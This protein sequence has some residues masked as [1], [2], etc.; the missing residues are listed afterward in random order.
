MSAK[1]IDDQD[2]DSQSIENADSSY[3][4]PYEDDATYSEDDSDQWSDD[5]DLS[6]EGDAEQ[7]QAPPKKKS[8]NLMIGVILFV[9]I[10]GVFGFM[11]LSG[12]KNAPQQAAP[13]AQVAIDAD[14][15]SADTQDA[16]DTAQPNITDLK[17]QADQ[18]AQGDQSVAIKAPTTPV[19]PPAPQQGLMENPDLL[20]D[21]QNA[22]PSVA[23]P[24]EPAPLLTGNEP[25][26]ATPSSDV[27]AA[28]SPTVK[29]VSDFPT[30]DSIKKPDAGTPALT[31]P[32]PNAPVVPVAPV[33][34]AEPVL[35]V[36]TGVQDNKSGQLQLQVNDA[37]TKIASLERQL[38]DKS[39]E[40]ETQK[41][42]AATALAAAS[43]VAPTSASDAEVDALKAKI[44]DLEE[45]LA[46]KPVKIVKERE[47]IAADDSS[48][49]DVVQT[50]PVKKA[51]VIAAKPKVVAKQ[52]S[53]KS[54]GTGKAILSDKATGDL[55]TVRVGDSVAGLGR[56]VSI[57]GGNSGW[58]VKGTTGSVSE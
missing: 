55:K 28:I 46:A 53:L 5:V 33:T 23:A 42:K 51:P 25:T 4:E 16:G 45:K 18:G 29:P 57:S 14:A 1:N 3:D 43:N 34:T 37:Q 52:W 13:D 48:T 56:I 49:E 32:A 10:I 41:Q 21:P 20:N 36:P 9:A 50:A 54:A 22:Q 7:E 31:A 11:A 44:S 27:V 2:L 24:V 38:A 58:T 17:N 47:I 19:A 6:D 8:S 39:A 40:L 35:P 30:V 26:S 12:N 15:D